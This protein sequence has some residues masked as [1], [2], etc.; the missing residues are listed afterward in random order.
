MNIQQIIARSFSCL[1]SLL[2]LTLLA[3]PAVAQVFDPGPSSSSLFDNVLNIPPDPDIIAGFPPLPSVGGDGLTTQINIFD[4]G[5]VTGL[6]TFSGAEVNISGGQL[7]LEL[8]GNGSEINVSGGLLFGETFAVTGSMVNIF[9]GGALGSNFNA[10]IGSMV[11]FHGGTV[12]ANFNALAGSDVELFGGEFQLNGSPYSGALISLEPGDYFTG[13]LS[14]G[15][16]FIFDTNGPNSRIDSLTDVQLTSTTLPNVDLSPMVVSTSDHNLPSGL[17]SG[18]ELTLLDGGQLGENYEVVNATLNIEG[19]NLAGGG[20]AINS[21]VNVSS[22][23]TGSF[24]TAFRGTVLNVSGGVLGSFSQ[25]D[26]GSVVNLS[27]GVVETGFDAYSGSVVNMSGGDINGSFGAK[28]G[29]VV[30]IRGGTFGET[31]NNVFGFFANS[32]SEVNLFGSNFALDGVSLDDSLTIDE[33]F[34]ITDRGVLLTGEF[35]DGSPFSLDLGTAAASFPGSIR[36]DATL[37]VTLVSPILLGDVNQDGL[38]NFL[39]INPF[40]SL[41]AS[42]TFLPQADCNLDGAVNFLDIAPFIAILAN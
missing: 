20:G 18:Q 22:G 8:V 19:G 42:N 16:T 32:G 30:N 26:F 24:F 41:L 23:S 31:R 40:I 10:S 39:D 7:R 36:A 17:R 27:G 15:S 28:N 37:T 5:M 4:G 13:T 35:D 1:L 6:S 29:S 2:G 25:A 33:A 12:G 14:D 34:T 3:A 21:T 9:N 11:N 38:V